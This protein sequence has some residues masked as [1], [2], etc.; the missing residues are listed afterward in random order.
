MLSRTRVD[1]T[2]LVVALA[3]AAED[4]NRLWLADRDHGNLPS[5]DL[6][7]ISWAVDKRSFIVPGKLP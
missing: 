1:L 3:R 5:S 2:Q 7:M 4:E 6:A